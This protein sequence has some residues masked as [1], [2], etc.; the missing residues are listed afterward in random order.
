MQHTLNPNLPEPEWI[1][2]LRAERAGG[3]S[4]SKIAR[5]TG[6]ARSSLSQLLSGT[7]PAR[8]LDHATRKNAARIIRLYRNQ[9]LCPHL[10]RGLGSQQCRDLAS[11]P[12]STSRPEKLRQWQACRHCP[13]NP[14]AGGSHDG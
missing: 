3:K 12:M 7:Y 8:S 6:L 14:L 1:T 5:E 13:L 2:L 10:R 9:V 11:A 4:V